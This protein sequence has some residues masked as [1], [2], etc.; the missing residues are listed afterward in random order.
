MKKRLSSILIATALLS[1]GCSDDFLEK[2]P[3]SFLS[4]EQ[5]SDAA[6]NNPAVAE[7]FIRGVYTY[8]FT[9]GTGGTTQH[10]DFGQK[11]YDI[12]MDM[13]SS[14]MALSASIYG[15]YR[16]VTD[17]QATLDFTDIDNYKAWRHYYRII[18]SCNLIIDSFGGNEATFDSDTAKWTYAQAKAMRAHSYFYLT[19]LYTDSYN[20][21]AAVLPI[22]IT[23]EDNVNVPKS[24]TQEV[25]DLIVADL[26]EAIDYLGDFDRSNKYEVNKYVAE[27]ILAYVHAYMGNNTAVLNLTADV[28]NNG[29]FTLAT[30]QDALGGFN[31]VNT[32]GWMW[33]VDL[34]LENGLDLVSWWGQMDLFSYSYAAAGDTK[35]IDLDLYNAIPADDVRKQQFYPDETSSFYLMPYNKFYDP[36]REVFSQRNITTDYIYMRVAEMYLL[37]AE[38][39]AK[40][41]NEDAARNALTALLQQRI[42]DASYVNGLSGQALVDEV[43]LQTRIELWGEGKSYLALKRNQRT[44]VRGANHLSLVGEPISY[45]DDRLTFEI[46]QAEI[47]DNPFIS[48]QN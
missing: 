20:P 17:Y 34:T 28:I 32:P 14:D 2:E 8:M 40:S 3:S 9:V 21:S 18:R 43:D 12:Y 24:T 1:V 47:R 33:G 4:A 30:Q 25:F 10:D 23:A 26:N 22:Y 44:V 5:V 37:Y 16:G 45:D 48:D 41:G 46:P 7:G 38:A 36:N 29:G 42:P 13:L 35:V 39:A 15:W 19:Q 11:G 27:G 6:E 31:D